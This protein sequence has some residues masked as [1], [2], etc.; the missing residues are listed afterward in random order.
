MLEQK[1]NMSLQN[2]TLLPSKKQEKNS[3]KMPQILCKFCKLFTEPIAFWQVFLEVCSV[4]P[5]REE[6]GSWKH[7]FHF[8]HSTKYWKSYEKLFTVCFRC[9]SFRNCWRFMWLNTYSVANWPNR[10]NY[11]EYLSSKRREDGRERNL[12][13]EDERERNLNLQK[14]AALAAAEARKQV[15]EAIWNEIKKSK[16]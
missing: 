13:K 12:K 14:E 4:H 6:F 1:W 2:Q 10:I 11:Q 3:R 15:L 7:Q 5:S 16:L 8:K 9:I